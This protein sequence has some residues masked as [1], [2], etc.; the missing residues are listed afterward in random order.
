MA[1]KC[2]GDGAYERLANAIII[3]AARDYRRTLMRLKKNP[4]NKEVMD[5]AMRLEAFFRSEWYEF[6]TIL[7]GEL[8]IKKLR[9]SI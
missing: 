1:V 9:K 8:L 7:D 4:K 6:L 2:V 5:E 3:Q